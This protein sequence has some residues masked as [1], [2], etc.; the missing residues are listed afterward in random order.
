MDP[1]D[2]KLN[3]LELSQK[4]T[5]RIIEDLQE[6]LKLKHSKV[7][8][9]LKFLQDFKLPERIF[10]FL[11]ESECFAEGDPSV[12]KLLNYIQLNHVVQLSEEILLLKSDLTKKDS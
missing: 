8:Q 11:T 3:I 5:G 9:I 4:E 2:E 1:S 7:E 10:N 12:Y 6:S